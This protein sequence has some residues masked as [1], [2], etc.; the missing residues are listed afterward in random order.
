MGIL[1]MIILAIAV[2]AVIGVGVA[3]FAGSKKD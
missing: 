1:T 2:A 3:L